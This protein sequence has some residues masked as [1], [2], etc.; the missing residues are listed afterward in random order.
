MVG[1]SRLG[2][3][4][5][6]LAGTLLVTVGS[7][8]AETTVAGALE[9]SFAVDDSGAATYSIPLSV[10]PG[11]AGNEP[12]LALSYSSQSGNGPLGIG[13]GLSGLSAITR[14]G[15]SLVPHG[16]IHG[17]DFSAED[18]FCLDGQQLV[19]ISGDYGAAGT[20][21]RTE[22]ESY[23][24]V[25]SNGSVGTGPESFT[26]WSKGGLIL[27]YG[28][29]D[30]SRI[31]A[32]K[33]DGTARPEARLWA[34]NKQADRSGNEISY[35]Y[36][37]DQSNGSYRINRIDYGSN[38]TA[39]TAPT[40][41]VRFVY[42]DR[43]DTRTWYQAGAKISQDKRLSKVQTFE[44]ETLVSDY[45][46]GYD[47]EGLS[48]GSRVLSI[49]QCTSTDCL[50]PQVLTYAANSSG[51]TEA[52]GYKS[53]DILR[54]YQ[55]YQEQRSELHD[56]NGDGLPD[57]VTS[58]VR[59]ANVGGGGA[60]KNIWLNTGSGWV[61][62]TV[63][64]QP[65]Y[66]R[67]YYAMDEQRG[68]LH[69]I[70]GD[71][72]PDWITSYVRKA[73]LYGGGAFKNI[74][75]NDGTK[76]VADTAFQQPDYLRD[77]YAMNE[78]RG[79]LHDINGDG[80]LDWVTAYVRRANLY[81]GGAFRN[82]WLNNGTTWVASSGYQPPT[83][84]I[85][86]YA[87]DERQSEL[88]DING[89][90][91][92]DWVWSFTRRNDLYGGGT[93]RKIWLNT[94]SGWAE[95]TGYVPPTVMWDYNKSSS[96]LGDFVD[97]N[98]DGLPDWVQAYIDTNGST[99]KG[100]WLNTGTGWQKD[101]AFD[102]PG[103]QH[104]VSQNREL[105]AFLDVNGD[106]ITD[107]VQATEENASRT[108]WLGT[109][110][111]WK[112]STEYQHPSYI[113]N[114]ISGYT[115]IKGQF[116]DLNGD[117][118][119]DWVMSFARPGVANGG[120][121]TSWLNGGRVDR[122]LLTGFTTSRGH[123]TE[124][125]YQPLTNKD[126]YN[127][128]SGA[129]YPEQDYVASLAVVKSVER[130]DGIGGK[131]RVDYS[132]AGAKVDVTRRAFLGFRQ[133]TSSDVERGTQTITDYRQDWPFARRTEKVTRQLVS[134]VA[135]TVIQGTSGTLS[136]VSGG[137]AWNTGAYSS[138]SFTGAG[139]LSVVARANTYWL[140][141]LSSSAGD[142]SD[143]SIE[144]GLYQTSN[145]NVS[146]YESGQGM[147]TFGSYSVGDILSVERTA[148]GIVNYKKNGVT[149]YTSLKTSSPDIALLVNASLYHVGTTLG[150]VSLSIAGGLA[151]S[152]HWITD[153]SVEV[154]PTSSE[155]PVD[156]VEVSSDVTRISV[157]TNTW[158]QAPQSTGI[159]DVRLKSSSNQQ[160]EINS[161]DQGAQ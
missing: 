125:S 112:Q 94:G 98:G 20:E 15:Q 159:V 120:F 29:T 16:K 26:V 158:E 113:S 35:S 22:I 138:E 64:Q 155:P 108:T 56:I 103:A 45:R 143:A 95:S 131:R 49:T 69:D 68:E 141:G 123:Q 5:F 59:K 51:W 3:A 10:P 124:V 110:R 153:A 101:P 78:Q 41:S 27:E 97:I 132:Y 2:L 17:V 83:H 55:S 72:L 102:L 39:G 82:I 79:E 75:L 21:Y 111:G 13:W 150:D 152:V 47:N 84:F 19:A 87:M 99:V 77:Y 149:I 23:A 147:G 109:G 161:S 11:I 36:T 100:T 156:T 37:E 80:L 14:C 60:F 44:A 42:E 9:G 96:K 140:V 119:P 93:L 122:D 105:G 121:R 62:D 126:R 34:L 128:G 104:N 148:T 71:G 53:P 66:L 74:W 57:W 154:I 46:M 135:G 28:K 115:E 142:L 6:Y 50:K 146:V 117:G 92:V 89:D 52:V 151:K 31:E 134:E 86:Y 18:R 33:A 73:N 12:R 40:S 90:G 139:T 43:T 107:W 7:A 85:D 130:D 1:L 48:G 133:I 63:F 114:R 61:A 25:I 145:G 127:K 136:K 8:R 160:Y 81:G 106:G 88:L 32:I 129:V 91:L 157:Q 144:F 38:A 67:D 58:Y 76:W 70:N 116:H 24:K 137:T 118:L 4:G 65:D 54:D 30:D